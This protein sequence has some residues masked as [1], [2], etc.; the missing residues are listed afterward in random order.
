MAS[1]LRPEI[2]RDLELDQRGPAHDRRGAH[3][4]G[5][6]PR[7]HRAALVE[8][9]R[10]HA[11]RAAA[12]RTGRLR[13]IPCARRAP[14]RAGAASRAAL[15]AGA[16]RSAAQRTRG[17]AASC[18]DSASAS[19]G[20][21]GREIADLIA[22]ATGSLG[23]F[24]DRSLELAAPQVAGAGQQPL[25][26]ARRSLRPGTLFGLLFH[27]LGGGQESQAGIRRARHG[28]HGRDHRRDG[29]GLSRP[30][31]RIAHRRPGQ[32]D[33]D[34]RRPRRRRRARGRH[35]DRR[36]HRRLER[37]PE[38]DFLR[39]VPHGGAR[40]RVSRRGTRHQDGRAL[41]Q[42]Q[43]RAGRGAAAQRRRSGRR[44]AAARAV[45]AR[46][47]ARRRATLLRAG[48]ARRNRRAALDRLPRAVAD[49]SVA[50]APP[51]AT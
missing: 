24:L 7:R 39:L 41:R 37:R 33:R 13:A 5:R 35:R 40:P 50:R 17:P 21:R 20:L 29:R 19:G 43:S 51:A 30:R 42:V 15:H 4:A 34:P 12:I 14:E 1:M 45:H 27:L 38:A 22:F 32:A 23:E 48:A 46:A 36:A 16:A 18:S 8:R 44:C 11:C 3:A 9:S 31:R 10:T 28:R 49:R 26:Q 47:L 6:D 2:I 25:R